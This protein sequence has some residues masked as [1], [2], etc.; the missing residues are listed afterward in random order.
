MFNAMMVNPN[1][2]VAV[3]IEVISKGDLVIIKMEGDTKELEAKEAIPIYH[4][5]AISDI[6][7]SWAVIKYNE[8]IGIALK[9]IK[10][11]THVHTHN[12]GSK[13]IECEGE[14]L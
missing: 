10:M 6:P 1:D 3:V 9:D 2:N 8:Q 14:Q 13:M 4:K 7:C 5:V 11:G 12:L